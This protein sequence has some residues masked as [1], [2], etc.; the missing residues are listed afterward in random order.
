MMRKGKAYQR[1]AELKLLLKYDANQNG[2]LDPEEREA[3]YAMPAQLPGFAKPYDL[4]GDG[5]LDETEPPV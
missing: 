1:D 3:I 2:I 5:T 4:N